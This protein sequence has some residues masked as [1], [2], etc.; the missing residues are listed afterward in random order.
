MLSRPLRQAVIA[1]AAVSVVFASRPAAA[2]DDLKPEQVRTAILKGRTWLLSQQ[3]DD[4]SFKHS[5]GHTIGKTGLAILALI[6]SG[7]SPTEPE[8][9]KGLKFLRDAKLPSATYE[10][11]LMLMALAAAKDKARDSLRIAA[12]VELLEDG[13][14]TA[15]KDIEGGW[16][17]NCPKGGGFLRPDRSNSQFAVL[18]LRDAMYAGAKVKKSTWLRIRK[19]W[20]D[21]QSG[22]KGWGYVSSG[23]RSRGSMTVA[24][25]SSL[26]IVSR[27]LDDENRA[28]NGKPN[29]CP[30]NKPYKKLEDGIAKLG[31]E[32]KRRGTAVGNYPGGS[33]NL[34]YYLYGLER[35]GR[36]SGRR[37]FGTRD[38]YRDGASFFVRAQQPGG[39]WVGRGFGES[40][41]I[42]A[43]CMALLFLS[44]GL[45][46]VLI[47]K[48]DYG[49]DP[50]KDVNWNRH[51]DD[52][53]NLTEYVIT[54]DKWPQLLTFQTVEMRKMLKEGPAEAR[55]ALDQSKVLL[56]TGRDRPTELINDPKQ[57]G[58]LKDYVKRGGFIFAVANCDRKGGFDAGFHDLVQKMFKDPNTG[59]TEAGMELKRLPKDHPI[60][61][62]EHNL[63]PAYKDI[64][65]YGVDFGCRT[66]I[67]FA[68]V[69][70][71]A[72]AGF[73]LSCYWNDWRLSPSKTR[74]P[75]VER[76][77]QVGINVLAYAT[78]REP[79]QKLQERDASLNK[80]KNP[81]ERGFLQVAKLKHTGDWDVA[82]RALRNLLLGLNRFNGLTASTKQ[83][84]ISPAD[85]NLFRYPVVYMHGRNGFSM[86]ATSKK[87]LKEYLSKR[88]GLLFA[89]ACCGAPA[90]DKSFRELMREL[91]GRGALKRIPMTHEIFTQKIGFDI[92]KVHRRM[93]ESSSKT[94]KINA[95][96][97]LVE[98][99][100]EGIEVEGRLVVIY[101]KLDI[102]CALERQASIACAGYVEKDALKIGINVMLYALLQDVRYSQLFE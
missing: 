5:A 54:R 44:K 71:D 100:L 64:E 38:W 47:N 70:Q 63:V 23:E 81:I 92:R 88:G 73:D 101:S 25:I 75:W 68:P 51:R 83:R 27:V 72:V 84:D 94:A 85:K 98:P 41:P 43:S 45:A 37:F 93:P 62:S 89:D 53:R 46:P 50:N 39:K 80:G 49:T 21:G 7:M 3:E 56:I 57:Y 52:A 99:Y 6:N 8:I 22:D 12:L 16:T 55:E 95:S 79:P 76:A 33:Q 19:Y 35:A 15:G 90:F 4:G 78:G 61:R 31:T 74:H 82:P 34:Y 11:S 18:A 86:S 87:Q 9:K 102:S 58:Y 30:E 59:K 77:M 48:L 29:C 26:V 65:L 28:K 66:A 32:I 14:Y 60:Y 24:G 91:F 97:K 69:G 96:T 67:V 13:Q 1:V 17:Y 10:I 40:E 20:E 36:L 42:V 2:A